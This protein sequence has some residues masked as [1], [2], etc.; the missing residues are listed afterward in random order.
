MFK[1]FCALVISC[2]WLSSGSH[3]SRGGSGLGFLYSSECLHRCAEFVRCR[4]TWLP[5]VSDDLCLMAIYLGR[6]K[7]C[8]MN[9]VKV[10]VCQCLLGCYGN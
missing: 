4:V 8:I 2:P 1:V 6:V 10:L 9:R 5:E 7:G 3:L